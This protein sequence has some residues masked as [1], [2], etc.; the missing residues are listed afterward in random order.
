MDVAAVSLSKKNPC[1]KF[2][3]TGQRKIIVN[4][5]KKIVKHQLENPDS[6]RMTLREMIVDISKSSGIG[7]RSV[8]N[9][10][11]EYKNQGTITSPNKKKIRPTIIEKID[12]FDKN[13]IRQKIHNFWRNREVPTVDKMLI[14]IN[15]DETLPNIKRSSFQKVLKDLQFQYVKKK[16]NSA[17]LEREDLIAW[18]RSYLVKIK[19]YREQN[20]PIYYLDETW[21]NAGDTH[22]RT[23]TDT[24]INSSRDAFLK[25]LTTG[26]KE[27]SGKGKRLIVLHIGSTDGFVPGGLLCFESKTN[28]TDYHDE[29]NGDTFYEWFVRILPLLKEN[30]VIVMDNASY[31]SVK[32]CKIPT[33]S[34]KKKDIIDW[35]EMKGEIVNH[36]IVKNDL[37]IRVKK[38]KNQYDKYVIDECAKDNGKIVLRLPPYHCELNPIELAWSSVKSYVR[39][40]NNT[41]KIKDVLEL[42][43]KGVEHVTAEM[44]T[45]FVGHVVKEEEKFLNIEHITDEVFDELPEA[46]GRHIMTITGDTSCSE[47]DFDS[48]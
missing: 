23:W 19:H 48:D 34:W 1:G 13:A 18:R 44:W 41:F 27:P 31:H 14:A 26:Q 33:M 20:R 45:N 3:G 25:G 35:L 39:T 37:I 40:H 22:S 43:K 42:L 8:Q 30:A 11:S 15:E 47:S 28:S 10:L 29:M 36:P 24:T 9:I 21:V 17:L 6:P 2:I 12:E 4:L 38:I 46:E 16:R 5:Y 7:Q 32:K